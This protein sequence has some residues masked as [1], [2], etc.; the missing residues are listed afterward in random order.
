MSLLIETFD[1]FTDPDFDNYR[2]ERWSSNVYNL[3]R[4]QAKSRLLALARSIPSIDSGLS[5]DA[6]SDRP[7]VWNQRAVRDQ[8]VYFLRQKN[9]RDHIEPYM[10]RQ[11]GLSVTVGDPAEH[12]RHALLYLKLDADG[13]E[14]GLA[15]HRRA[16]VDL[17]NL[18]ARGNREFETLDALCQAIDKR[19][20]MDEAEITADLLLSA[21]RRCLA[22]EIEEVSINLR[23]TR[24]RACAMGPEIQAEIAQLTAP[25]SALFNFANWSAENDQ[26]NLEAELATLAQERADKAEAARVRA[27][28]AARDK[29]AREA[30]A[31]ELTAEKQADDQAW[32]AR[33]RQLKRQHDEE[34]QA[35]L[36]AEAEAKKAEA[37]V[38]IVEKPKTEA[39][40]VVEAELSE[41]ARDAQAVEKANALPVEEKASDAVLSARTSER[42]ATRAPRAQKAETRAPRA[43]KAEAKAPAAK[44]PEAERKPAAKKAETKAPAAKK[45]EAERKPAA[46]KAEPKKVEKTEAATK[47]AA[48]KE[49][50]VGMHCHMNRG[51]LQGKDGEILQILEKGY[52]R[53]RV[54]V[55]EVNVSE[56][57]IDPVA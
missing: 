13:L 43:Q 12:H 11:A 21:A 2:V 47:P 41:E 42:H 10:D 15:L 26:I 35:K 1:A 19:F 44:K 52:V 20:K 50:A 3:A 33:N 34:R 51:L 36:A 48:K 18:L 14:L 7:S 53:V 6:S 49:L 31:R 39:P 5:L 24:Q 56:H 55:L 32:R 27:E 54:G 9:E 22:G 29:A 57:D 28:E 40:K 25:I 23:W 45:P 38:E 4:M 46:K 16:R 30:S 17:E 8:W 37:P